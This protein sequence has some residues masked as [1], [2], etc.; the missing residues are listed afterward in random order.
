MVG[1]GK[2]LV[3]KR[4]NC[5]CSGYQYIHKVK[6]GVA[7]HK[8]TLLSLDLQIDLYMGILNLP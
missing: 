7:F 3:T 8:V 1:S 5:I 4:A 2:A 6:L